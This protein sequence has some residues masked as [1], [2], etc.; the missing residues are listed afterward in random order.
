MTARVRSTS[1][2][3]AVRGA[4]VVVAI[5][6]GVVVA[7]VVSGSMDSSNATLRFMGFDADR[8][9]M[10]TALMIAGAAAAVATLITNRSGQSTLAGLGSLAALFG[11]TF[12]VETHNALA[13][14]DV[15]GTFSLT[16]WVL[17]VIALA[18][19]GL[20]SSWAG[21]ALAGVLR[22]GLIEAGTVVR[23]AV[24]SRRLS[25]S[26]LR[27]PLA[28]AV[29]AI[30]VAMSVPV[31][32]DMVNYKPDAPMLHGG[33]PP[34]GLI[35]AEL[36]NLP[37]PVRRP[38]S[39]APSA[40]ETVSGSSIQPTPSAQPSRTAPANRRP[41]LDW[42]PSGNGAITWIELPAPWTDSPM[43]TNSLSVYTPPGYDPN[44]GRRYPVLYEAPYEVGLWDK[45]M[46][47]TVVMDNLIDTGAIPPML[48]VFVNTW[49][50]PIDDTEC[51]N[52]ADG[53]QWVDTYLSD[54][55]VAYMDTHFLTIARREARA[56]TGFSQGGYCA[57]IVP[58]KHPTVFGTGIPI[59]GYYHVGGGGPNSLLPFA[60]NPYALAAASPV[61]FARTLS[62][63]QREMLF[64]IVVAD[65][66]QPFFG[67]EAQDLLRVL[68]TEGYEY[69]A[70]DSKIGH[71]WEQ[72]RHELPVALAA[73]ASHMVDSGV[74]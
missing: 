72:V 33:A 1:G 9:Q 65:L 74:F 45:S 53:R 37:T 18:M 30:L 6:A 20:I 10:I 13:P 51:A 47:F 57:A 14:S 73:W 25:R 67:A 23:D 5:A 7:A 3:P 52:S 40:A 66:S 41:W 28:V 43:K 44:G 64:F 35:P 17:T 55:V 22:P 16:G 11:P 24:R 48:V 42:R 15:I 63:A 69:L 27:R 31:F 54:T 4:V 46:N 34:V 50:A 21:S 58:L 12:L 38:P 71:G 8:A 29:V 70:I 26:L 36:S 19:S 62:Q 60:G 49:Q 56:F 68:D 39:P 59:S 2:W 32:G 61:D